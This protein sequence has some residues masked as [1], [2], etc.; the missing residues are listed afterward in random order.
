M[1]PV[2]IL[3]KMKIQSSFC[4]FLWIIIYIMLLKFMNVKK[5]QLIKENLKSKFETKYF[6]PIKKIL[7]MKIKRDIFEKIACVENPLAYK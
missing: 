7:R 5:I 1:I 6:A 2:F 3:E 4:L